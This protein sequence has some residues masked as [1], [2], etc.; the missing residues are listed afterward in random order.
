VSGTGS[1]VSDRPKV[2]LALVSSSMSAAMSTASSVKSSSSAGGLRAWTSQ[3]VSA[4]TS[5]E[6]DALYRKVGTGSQATGHR[7]FK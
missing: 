3:P 4:A 6:S 7:V 2:T 5:K 1:N